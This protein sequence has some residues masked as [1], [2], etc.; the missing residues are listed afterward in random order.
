[1]GD[2]PV[3]KGSH[4]LGG[5]QPGSIDTTDHGMKFWERQANALSRPGIAAPLI[6]FAASGE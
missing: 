3:N 2:K 1:M 5:E 6:T 4:D